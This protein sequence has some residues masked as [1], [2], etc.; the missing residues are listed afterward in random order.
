VTVNVPAGA[1]ASDEAISIAV[2]QVGDYPAIPSTFTDVTKVYAFLPHGLQF[3]SPVTIS[4]PLPSNTSSLVAL[5]AELNGSWSDAHASFGSDAVISTSSF[6]F[7][8]LAT[9][10]STCTATFSG[11]VSGTADCSVPAGNFQ[12]TGPGANGWWSF[13][14][15]TPGAG[16]PIGGN[17]SYRFDELYAEGRGAMAA[18]FGTGV[19]SDSSMEVT[20]IVSGPSGQEWYAG[21]QFAQDAGPPLEIGNVSVTIESLGS[22]SDGGSVN[23]VTYPNPHGSFSATLVGQNGTNGSVQ[24][25]GTF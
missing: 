18:T 8:T 1:L 16:A 21:W 15:G 4:L 11:A 20:A 24:M 3:S 19:E 6:S 14:F 17:N 2:A 23:D 7:Y 25:D 9:S 10:A 22:P 13:G 5:G 12:F